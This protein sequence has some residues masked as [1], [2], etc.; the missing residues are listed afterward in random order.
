MKTQK[1]LI[2]LVREYENQNIYDIS[3]DVVFYDQT[4]LKLPN[5]IIYDSQY[6]PF[7]KCD[8]IY[9]LDETGNQ[10]ITIGYVPITDGVV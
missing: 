5:G 6:D 4:F 1:E 10:P 3:E 7:L 2:E 8:C 9:A